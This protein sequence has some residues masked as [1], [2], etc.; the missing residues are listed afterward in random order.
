M[1]L[2]A[3]VAALGIA[4]AVGVAVAAADPAAE[5]F[6]T[7]GAVSSPGRLADSDSFDNSPIAPRS[8]DTWSTDDEPDGSDSPLSGT[9]LEQAV[10][11]ALA[12]TAGGIVTDSEI[13]DDGA[14]Y[15]VEIRKADGSEVEVNLDDAFQ[16]T[17]YEV[18]D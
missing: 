3:G 17:G 1:W 7:N 14:A 18:D 4:A 5:Q 15:G 8:L 16:V 12:Y 6:V 11:A 9:D 2:G 10:A 13:G